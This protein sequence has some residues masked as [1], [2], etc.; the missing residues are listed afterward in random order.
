MRRRW[1]ADINRGECTLMR[2]DRCIKNH[3]RQMPRVS[4]ISPNE[5]AVHCRF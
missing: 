2:T 1:M 4:L 5:F 3:V